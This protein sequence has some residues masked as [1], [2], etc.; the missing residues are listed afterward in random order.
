MSQK[1]FIVD[2]WNNAINPGERHTRQCV[3]ENVGS[4]T[5]IVAAG[6]API[7]VDKRSDADVVALSDT[8]KLIHTPQDGTVALEFRFR[9]DGAEDD[10]YEIQ[11]Y[12]AAGVDHYTK[13]ADLTCTQG[14]QDS[15]SEHFID[16][17]TKTNEDWLTTPT[18]V[19][20]EANQI[21]RYVMNTHGYSKFLFVCTDLQTAT[22]FYAD[23]RR[24]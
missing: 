20:S 3:W 17:I 23:V 15:D 11:L 2:K 21:A 8:K 12:V 10:A 5:A 19:R 1:V 16:T 22:N 14:T 7:D 9:A 6:Q 24:I 18:I 4:I 13:H